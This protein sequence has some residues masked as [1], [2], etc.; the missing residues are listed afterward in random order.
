MQPKQ[1]ATKQPI[2]PKQ[3]ATTAM[4][5]KDA[6]PKLKIVEKTASPLLDITNQHTNRKKLHAKLSTL[7]QA[8]LK[9]GAVTARATRP[10]EPELIFSP[11]RP[12]TADPTLK[13]QMM[14]GVPANASHYISR[15]EE[16]RGILFM[17]RG[18]RD[19]GM[20][21]V[22]GSSGSGKT[23]LA[24]MLAYDNM[25]RLRFPDGVVWLSPGKV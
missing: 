8:V 22:C 12:P 15:S 16:I 24:T 11:P 21:A 19:S 20:A 5:A 1:P 13:Q 14:Y 3:T 7:P 4:E 9:T 17:L 6:I 2:Q 18:A 23:V 25:T 10:F